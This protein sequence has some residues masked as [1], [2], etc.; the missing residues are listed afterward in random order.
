MLKLLNAN[1]ITVS[2]EE[3]LP[4]VKMF[5]VAL[6]HVLAVFGGIVTAPLIIALGMQLSMEDTAYLVSASLVVSGLATVIQIYR[7]GAVGS[8]L[9]SIQGTSFTFIGPLIFS[10][11]TVVEG[12][13][14]SRALG[15]VLGTCGVC[16]LCMII[17]LQFIE[18]L[19]RWVTT[20][21]SGTTVILIGASLVWVTINNLVNQFSTAN[22]TVTAYP[23][24]LVFP[25]AIGVFTLTLLLALSRNNFFRIT[26]ITWGL[27]VGL[28]SAWMLGMVDTAPLKKFRYIF[29]TQLSAV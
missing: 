18:K 6:Q 14:S 9:L 17:V 11:F 27:L 26:S 24:W 29:S 22:N 4:P 1:K 20:N 25:V 21:V 13:T 7:I 16:S 5:F 15:L 3:K 12:E 28:A 10:Y 2:F 23:A 8:G 19:Q